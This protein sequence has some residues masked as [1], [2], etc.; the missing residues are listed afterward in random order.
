V[1]AARATLVADASADGGQGNS[2][3]GRRA[4]PRCLSSRAIYRLLTD[5]LVSA[6]PRARAPHLPGPLP[7]QASIKPGAVHPGVAITL[8]LYS[9]V[10]SEIEAAEAEKLDRMLKA[11]SESA[12]NFG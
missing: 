2:I 6:E 4:N 9:H 1:E 5:A 8:N 11:E 12:A 10:L 7:Q 3:A